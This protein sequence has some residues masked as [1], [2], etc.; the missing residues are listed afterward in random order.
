[1]SNYQIIQV[2]KNLSADKKRSDADKQCTH[3]YTY[4]YSVGVD[5]VGVGVGVFVH[6]AEFRTISCSYNIAN[7]FAESFSFSGG[8][9]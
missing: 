9:K 4:T 7:V 8:I 1:M 6:D 5:V 2:V 3:N